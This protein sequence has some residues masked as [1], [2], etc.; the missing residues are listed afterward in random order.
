VQL[1]LGL[2]MILIMKILDNYS[3]GLEN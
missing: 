1:Y 2:T 3:F